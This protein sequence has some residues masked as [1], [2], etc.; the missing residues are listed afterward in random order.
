MQKLFPGNRENLIPGNSR[1]IG[2]R[3]FPGTSTKSDMAQS[4]IIFSSIA[5]LIFLQEFGFKVNGAICFGQ[6]K[7]VGKFAED[8]N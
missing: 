7:R 4:L 8:E 2:N 3:E 1:E 6:F 5:S